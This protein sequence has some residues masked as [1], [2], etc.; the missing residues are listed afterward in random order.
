MPDDAAGG[1]AS[2][3]KAVGNRLSRGIGALLIGAMVTMAVSLGT[4]VPT[5]AVGAGCVTKQGPIGDPF[6]DCAAGQVFNIL[7]PGSNG[8]VFPG[9]FVKQQAG[10]P[11]TV[12]HQSDQRALYADLVKRAPNL[13]PSEIAN[14][15]KDAGFDTDLSNPDSVDTPAPG[16]VIIRDSSFGVPHIFGA[17]RWDTE[18]G[19]G[20]ASAQDR[21]FMMDV[22]RHYGRAKLS[23]FLGPSP[24]TV[25]MDCGMSAVAGYSEEELQAQVDNFAAKYPTPFH[26]D[27]STATT[28]GEQIVQDGTAYVQGVNKYI[29]QALADKHKMPVEY[30]ALQQVPALWKVTDIIA[31]ATL[32]QAIFAT[33]GGGEVGSAMMYQELTNRYGV[34]KGSSMWHDF[35]SQNDPQAVQSLTQSFPYEQVP[36]NVDPASRAMPTAWP[37]GS[38]CNGGPAPQLTPALGQVTVGPV[39]VDLGQL[40]PSTKPPH[41]SNQLIVDAAHSASGHPIAVFGPQTG[42]FAPE[43]LHE[44]DLHGPGLQARGVS[45]PGTE[46][47]VELGRGVDYSWSATSAG[48]DITDQRV[49]KLCNTDGTPATMASTAYLYNGKCVP[50]YERT[51]RQVSMTGANGLNPPS[52]VTIQIE[53]SVHGP[54]AGRTTAVDPATGQAIPVAIATERSTWGDELGSAPAF[55]EWNDPDIIHNATD[56][57]RAAAKETGTFN[58]SYVDSH[59]IAYYMSGLL[60]ARSQSADPNFPVWGTGQWDWQGYVPADLSAQDV[61]PRAINPPSGFF[62]NWNNKPAPDF[63]AADNQWG[64]GPVYRVQSLTDR[65][66]A[67]INNRLATPADIVNAMEDGGTV[68]LDGSQLVSPMATVLNGATLTPAQSSAL[69]TLQTWASDPAWAGS[70]PGAHRR[71]RAGSGAYEQGNAV[72]IMDDLYPR[73]THAI[74]DPWLS[75]G[76]YNLLTGMNGINNPPGPTGSAYDGGWEGYLQRSLQQ[77]VGQSASPYSQSYCGSGSL[78]ACQTALTAALQAT[79]DHLTAAYGTSDISQWTCARSNGSGRC[80]P[81]NDDIRFSAVGVASIQ[82]MP[83]VNRPTFQ[84]VAQYPDHR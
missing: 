34:A 10:Q 43:I 7:P 48:A 11:V 59:D 36:A 60:P 52:V 63:S 57:Q 25:A 32:V 41:A 5:K 1:T 15:Y 68:D 40:L 51:D 47:F 13:Q 27:T 21:L 53:R 6:V 64:Y 61:H 29:K 22:L 20:Y 12:N 50:M 23:S 4:S 76:Q 71:D 39:T 69:Q 42:Y 35:R 58:W 14:F 31:T 46:V 44:I 16:V 65:V 80:N 78:A 17:T 74:F 24:G 8:L 77:A 82:P 55:L 70:V 81:G 83:W 2:G 62:T 79:I 67:V 19:S 66:Q 33:G 45:F 56:F 18:F 28:E 84:Q 72:A 75:G 37:S 54:I 30:P 38:N 3:G 49:E 9:Q 73:L 26:A